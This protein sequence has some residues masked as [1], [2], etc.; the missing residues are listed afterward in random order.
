M[1][2]LVQGMGRGNFNIVSLSPPAPDVQLRWEDGNTERFEVAEVHPDEVPGRGSLLRAEEE[3]RAKLSPDEEVHH[4]LPMDATPAIAR[5]VT[6][7]VKKSSGY[8]LGAGESPSLLLVGAL[9]QPSTIVAIFVTWPFLTDH[10]LNQHLHTTLE[11]SSFERT[12]LHL[13]AL[14]AV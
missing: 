13:Q 5:R 14:H 9:L 10:T 12:Y 8:T 11:S 7:K 6:E 3:K 4:W 1:R 2:L